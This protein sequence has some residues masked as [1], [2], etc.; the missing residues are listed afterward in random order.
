MRGEERKMKWAGQ[1][2]VNF[3]YLGTLPASRFGLRAVHVLSVCRLRIDQVAGERM[4]RV[5]G[6]DEGRAGKLRETNGFEQKE[7]GS[8]RFKESLAICLKNG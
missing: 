8:N 7:K 3:G 5:G 2:R 4:G 6:G 1:R